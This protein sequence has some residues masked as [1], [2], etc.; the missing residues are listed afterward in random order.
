[1][2]NLVNIYALHVSATFGGITAECTQTS[3]SVCTGIILTKQ[4]YGAFWGMV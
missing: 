4:K 3:T 1:M 2:F